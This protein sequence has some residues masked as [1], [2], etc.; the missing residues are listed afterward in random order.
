M[1][2]FKIVIIGGGFAGLQAA[3]SLRRLRNAEV[4]LIDKTGIATMV[5]A[6]PDALSGRLRMDKLFRP[7]PELTG[8]N[9]GVILDTV[10]SVSLAD[11]RVTCTGGTYAY[12]GIVISGGSV[13]VA[14]P[15][16]FEGPVHTVNSLE[17]A[18][19]LRAAIEVRVGPDPLHLVVAGAGYT[20]L[21]IAAAAR[22][23]VPDPKA[24]AITVVDSAQDILPMLTDRQHSTVRAHLAARSIALR[25]STSVRR[26]TEN[27]V[28]LSDATTIDNALFVWS[29]GMRAAPIEFDERVE[30]TPDGRIATTDALGLPGHPEVFV[31]G[32]QAALTRDG[33]VLRRAVNFAFYSGRRAGRNLAM[34]LSGRR[35]KP[36][37]PVDLG[38]VLPLIETSAGRIFGGL[39]IGGR[40]GLRLHYLMCGFRH[41]SGRSSWACYRAAL[42][43]RRTP[44]PLAN[45]APP[46][47]RH[48]NRS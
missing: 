5:P 25:T 3:R 23:G 44:T 24:L 26:T 27:V 9:L 40:L 37:V 6:L 10:E 19:D 28:E 43:L 4:S 47:R 8:R 31:A 36:F 38:W 46:G 11:R 35:P 32:D 22:R 2:R 48:G 33:T 21:E 45:T 13:P 42:N 20:G 34:H 12:D 30:R 1:K 7:L 29:A 18:G 14:V 15:P 41:F 17:G 39:R 16:P